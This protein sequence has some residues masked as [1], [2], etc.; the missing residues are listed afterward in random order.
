MPILSIVRL[1]IAVSGMNN[2][3]PACNGGGAVNSGAWMLTHVF[4]RAQS[5]A[6]HFNFRTSDSQFPTRVE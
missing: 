2:S 1:N 6:R 3:L 4:M 5:I